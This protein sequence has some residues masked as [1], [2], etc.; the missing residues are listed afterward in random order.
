MKGCQY[1]NSLPNYLFIAS[2][3]SAC[4]SATTPTPEFST[5]LAP[6]EQATSPAPQ[7]T[8]AGKYHS[9][10]TRTGIAEIDAILAAVESGDAQEL[11]TCSTTQQLRV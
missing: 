3:I 6:T 2:I 11:R 8:P 4:S 5:Q 7:P 1:E 9:L 10:D